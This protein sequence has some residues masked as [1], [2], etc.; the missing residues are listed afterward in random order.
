VQI[1]QNVNV[2]FIGKRY[3]FFGVSVSLILIGLVSFLVRG[4]L[5]LGI[6]F[7]GGI[8]MQISFAQTVNIDDIRSKLTAAS[9]SSFE[10]QSAQGNTIIIRAKSTD[11]DAEA[12]AKNIQGVLGAAYASNTVTLDRTEYVGPAVGRHLVKQA[13]SAILFSLLGIILYVAVRFHSGIW[14]MAG[15][16]ALAHDVVIV[17]GMFALFNYEV[18]LTIVAAILT[19]AGYSIN[20]TIVIFDRIRENRRLMSK[21]DFGVIINKSVNQTLPRTF[22]TSATTFAVVLAL[23]FFG[24]AVIHDFAFALLVGIIVG[25]YSSVYVASPLV[26]EWEVYRK[27]RA[28][29]FRMKK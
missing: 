1:L 25:T 2:D 16:I 15:V 23:Y 12:F 27:R 18:S 29:S 8:L 10:L 11:I 13:L 6:D 28:M 19:L 5:N 14:G 22:N 3:L 7:K 4:G 26:Y 20:D 24:G 9:I 21:E 17:L